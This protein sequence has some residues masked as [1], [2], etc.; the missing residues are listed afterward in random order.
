L[1]LEY[2]TN[3]FKELIPI[4]GTAFNAHCLVLFIEWFYEY[5]RTE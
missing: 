3:M 2:L 1:K 5:W 4:N